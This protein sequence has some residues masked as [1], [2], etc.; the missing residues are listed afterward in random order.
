M[1]KLDN[2]S[3]NIF[4]SLLFVSLV[5]FF[6]PILAFSFEEIGLLLL[7]FFAPVSILIIWV[8]CRHYKVKTLVLVS[9]LFIVYYTCIYVNLFDTNEINMTTLMESKEYQEPMENNSQNSD[10]PTEDSHSVYVHKNGFIS[11]GDNVNDNII[12]VYIANNKKGEKYHN[13]PK[14]SNMKNPIT[15]PLSEAKQLYEK[16]NKCCND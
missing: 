8:A 9:C 7:L 2:D 14:C 1:F 15:I 12:K 5:L 16:C 3:C 13:N 11:V 4:K 6:L 10:V